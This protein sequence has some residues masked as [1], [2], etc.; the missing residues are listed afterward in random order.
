METQVAPETVETE[1]STTVAGPS[2]PTPTEIS[3]AVAYLRAKKEAERKWRE[4]I[5]GV[6]LGEIKLLQATKPGT[7]ARAAIPSLLI[8][9]RPNDDSHVTLAFSIAALLDARS[10]T[11]LTEVADKAR[12]SNY[13]TAAFFTLLGARVE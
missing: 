8:R 1:A 6:L 4:A 13:F 9:S 12:P 11:P 10:D 7:P 2:E 3:E 5:F